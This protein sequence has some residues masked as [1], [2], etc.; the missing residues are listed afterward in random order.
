METTNYLVLGSAVVFGMTAL[1]LFS[2]YSRNRSLLRDL[3]MLERSD[4][5]PAKKKKTAK[6]AAPKKA[7]A[8]K[9]TAKKKAPAKKKTAKKK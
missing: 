5:R 3:E 2:L 1:H 4:T 8:K 6:K 9:K 7:A